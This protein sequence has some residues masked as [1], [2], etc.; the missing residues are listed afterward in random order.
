M[1]TSKIIDLEPIIEEC[2]YEAD[3]Y[4]WG[5]LK[6]EK[7]VGVYQG[8]YNKFKVA[9]KNQKPIAPSNLHQFFALLYKIEQRN[10]KRRAKG[11]SVDHE[12]NAAS[13][14]GPKN[15]PQKEEWPAAT[16]HC[17]ITPPIN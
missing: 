5:G 4:D 17:I 2:A 14:H 11:S 13:L 10:D 9:M 6:N 8:S 12:S 3:P 7:L 16:D 15:L 1:K